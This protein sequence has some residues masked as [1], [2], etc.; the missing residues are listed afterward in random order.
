MQSTI[1]KKFSM[2]LLGL[3]AITLAGLASC[4]NENQSTTPAKSDTSVEKM[5]PIVTD[6]SKMKMDTTKMKMDTMKKMTAP[7]DTP[8]LKKAITRPVVPNS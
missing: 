6:T 5:G 2:A 4:N 8:K 7:M 1:S 3:S